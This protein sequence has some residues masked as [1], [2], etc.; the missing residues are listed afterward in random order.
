MTTEGRSIRW[1]EI[2]EEL[3]AANGLP[4]SRDWYANLMAEPGFVFH[5]KQTVC[6]DLPARARPVT[7]P[8][9]R[10]RVLRELLAGIG[11]DGDF[12]EWF[13]A[14][15]IIEVHFLEA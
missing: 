1:S 8:A 14:S 13:E 4:G 2:S 12:D 6:V 11:R 10:R 7:E 3:S 9:E 5:L 15:P